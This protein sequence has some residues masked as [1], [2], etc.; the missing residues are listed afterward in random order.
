MTTPDRRHDEVLLQATGL[1]RCC[2]KTP[3][4]SPRGPPSRPVDWPQRLTSGAV[5]LRGKPVL[6]DG[7]SPLYSVHREQDELVSVGRTLD[8][9][10]EQEAAVDRLNPG[11]V[12]QPQANQDLW[13]RNCFESLP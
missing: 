12:D 1:D 10:I 2:A 11:A 7:L 5:V 4:D 9:K 3:L 6:A 13:K 8:W